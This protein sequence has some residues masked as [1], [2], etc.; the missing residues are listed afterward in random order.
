MYVSPEFFARIGLAPEA[1]LAAVDTAFRAGPGD[2]DCRILLDVV[3]HWGPESAERVLS[4]HEKT[5]FESVVGFG[6]GG[7]EMSLPAASFSGVYARARALGLKTSVHS[8]E[9]A[10]PESITAALDPLRPDRVAH[11]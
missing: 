8:G 11:A 5:R 9:W 1:C 3:R 10:G 4:L 6:M 7:D 2:C